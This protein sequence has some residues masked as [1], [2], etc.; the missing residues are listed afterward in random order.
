M[1]F[2]TYNL[3]EMKEKLIEFG[4]PKKFSA[5]GNQVTWYKEDVE[6]EKNEVE[7]FIDFLYSHNITEICP[8]GQWGR[9]ANWSCLGTGLG[10]ANITWDFVADEEGEIDG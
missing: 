2:T 7:S 3:E 9:M 4:V 8:A 1:E 6:Q 10:I 5:F